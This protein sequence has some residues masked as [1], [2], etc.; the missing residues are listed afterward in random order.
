MA[1]KV[2]YN[3][4]AMSKSFVCSNSNL[5]PCNDFVHRLRKSSF[6]MYRYHVK[7][8]S[9]RL[10]FALHVKTIALPRMYFKIMSYTLLSAINVFEVFLS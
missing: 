10:R 7:G 4:P 3:R 8:N 9:A 5:D 2:I 6:L 1:A